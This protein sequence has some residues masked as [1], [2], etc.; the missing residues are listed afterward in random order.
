[1]PMPSEV[2][3]RR[4]T[5]LLHTRSSVLATDETG[6]T[7]FFVF[8]AGREARVTVG[9]CLW[10]FLRQNQGDDDVGRFLE[11]VVMRQA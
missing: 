5:S 10:C 9:F 11:L 4:E 2:R 8:G 1:M 7:I 6:G 3:L